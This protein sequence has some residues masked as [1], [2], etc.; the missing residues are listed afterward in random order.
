MNSRE[1]VYLDYLY[2]IETLKDYASPKSKLTQ[3]LKTKQLVKIRRGLYLRAVEGGY[4]LKT[5][6]NKIYGPS[7]LSFEFALSYYGL[8]PERVETVTSASMGKNK[9][10]L[11]KTPVGAFSY[12]SIHPS[13]YPYDV[14]RL[15]EDGHPFLIATKEK[16]LCDLLSKQSSRRD[17]PAMKALLLDDLRL[18][19][20]ELFALDLDDL[21]FLKA[22][23]GKKNISLLLAFLSGESN[24][25]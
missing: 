23:Y 9:S 21:R 13:I 6:A 1:P 20:D 16:A 2:L 25:A 17:V 8:I 24:H 15:E 18:D 10:K 3:M 12:Q 14:V 4:S 19:R 7:Y 11:F 22:R 5:L